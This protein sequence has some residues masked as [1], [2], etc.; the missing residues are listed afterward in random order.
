MTLKLMTESALRRAIRSKLIN[1]AT[2]S[3]D[4]LFSGGGGSTGTFDIGSG[5]ASGFNQNFKS[6]HIKYHKGGETTW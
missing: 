1:E 5:G 3:T 4:K 6:S 2:M